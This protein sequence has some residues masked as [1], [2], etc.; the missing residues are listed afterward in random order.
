MRLLLVCVLFAVLSV[1]IALPPF[2]GSW[3]A[4][5]TVSYSKSG[6]LSLTQVNITFFENATF[7]LEAS[8]NSSSQ[9][10][11]PFAATFIGIWGTSL[12]YIT[13]FLAFPT[14]TP[15]SCSGSGC[16]V[17]YLI[18]LTMSG[19]FPYTVTKA[20]DGTSQY[21]VIAGWT[22][23]TLPMTPAAEAS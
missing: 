5:S 13:L 12:D 21:L 14:A 16:V 18:P 4:S 7:F 11:Y 8:G 10:G 22:M 2:I 15:A 20:A 23:P 17:A 6:A 1:V 19:S 3:E 9:T